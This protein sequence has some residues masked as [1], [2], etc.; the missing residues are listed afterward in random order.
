M[1]N[2]PINY[3]E[4]GST[5][6]A[7]VRDSSELRQLLVDPWFESETIIVKPNWVSTE[8]AD[9]TDAKTMRMLFEA[10]DSRIVVTESHMIL[11]SMNLHAGGKNFTAG[12]KEV[13][14]KWLLKGDGWN[15]LIENP[16][17]EWFKECGQWDQI[18]EEEQFFLDKY[19]FTDLFREFDVTYINVTEEVWNGRIANPTDVKRLVTS[20]FKPVQ[21]VKLYS[22]IPNKLYELLGSTFI[23]FAKLKTY[24]SFTMKNLFGM[25]PDPLRPYWHGPKNLRSTTNIVDINKIYHSLF[26]IY[27]ICEAF[28][29]TGVPHPEGKFQGVYTGRYNVI[30]GP[31]VVVF[32]RDLVSLDAILLHLTEGSITESPPL[33]RAPIELAEKEFGSIDREALKEAKIKVGSWLSP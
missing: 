25:I 13:N 4:F 26:N 30:E 28:F 7:K 11:R 14:W 22:M 10:L 12:N 27:G 16:D 24:A 3:Y 32:G 8:P 17:W 9:F 29:A 5:T 21:N 31:G 2:T 20:R 6:I 18:K 19:G 33:N 23:S 1:Q 15:W